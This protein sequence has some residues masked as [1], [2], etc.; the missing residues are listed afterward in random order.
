MAGIPLSQNT[1]PNENPSPTLPP[2]N[3]IQ[4]IGL[5]PNNFT[6][7]QVKEGMDYARN[8]GWS[9]AEI[10]DYAAK[11]NI[12]A[13]QLG[14]AGGNVQG[15]ADHLAGYHKAQGGDLMGVDADNTYAAA[16][17]YGFDDATIARSINSTYALP[18]KLDAGS[19]NKFGNH[20][21]NTRVADAL[22]ALQPGQPFNFAGGSLTKNADT[23]ELTYI[24]ANGQRSSLAVGT[25]TSV[26]GGAPL[27]AGNAKIANWLGSR[28]PQARQALLDAGIDPDA[29]RPFTGTINEGGIRNPL[30]GDTSPANRTPGSTSA[31]GALQGAA[32]ASANA[33]GQAGRPGQARNQ[34]WDANGNTA[35][36][37]TNKYMDFNHPLV[38]QAMTQ[39]RQAF[40]A[41]GLENSSMAEQAALQ[42]AY[43]VAQQ[44][45]SQDAGIAAQYGLQGNQIAGQQSLQDQQLLF[46]GG[47]NALNRQQQQEL[48]TQQLTVQERQAGLSREQATQ[49][50]Q[51]Q[52][53]SAERENALGRMQQQN[54]QTQQLAEQRFS[55]ITS[56]ENAAA[57]LK[58]NNEISMRQLDLSDRQLNNTIDQAKTQLKN[59]QFLSFASMVNGAMGLKDFSADAKANMMNTIADMYGVPRFQFGNGGAATGAMAPG[60]V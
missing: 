29:Y 28:S 38:Q 14:A 32:L 22:N 47:E 43:N 10:S 18:T 58:S 16:K 19:V 5:S 52:I 33:P 51:M 44:M 3:I 53:G 24:D 26:A 13:G 27:D 11:N 54:L 45:A 17:Q 46:Q 12:T 23:G 1:M 8:A 2:G 50:A 48:Q 9:D 60:A 34:A 7:G 40:A 21:T 57:Q 39:A 41:R 49:L 4:P 6:A 37:L 20:V 36:N 15:Y 30:L 59:N 25:G 42:A 56:A 31:I 55:T 35:Y